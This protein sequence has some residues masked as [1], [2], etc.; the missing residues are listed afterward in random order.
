MLGAS[1]VTHLFPLVVSRLRA[2]LPGPIDVLAAIGNGRSYGRW[3]HFLARELP[4][5]LEC[6]LWPALDERPRAELRALLGD[7]GNDLVY[8]AEVAEV[9]GWIERILDRLL[10]RGARCALVRLPLENLDGLSPLRFRIARSV[11]YPGRAI[12][13][14]DLRARALDLDGCLVEIAGRR[15]VA[16]VPQRAEWYGLDPIHVLRGRREEVCRAWLAPL[17]ATPSEDGA[18]HLARADRSAFRH[19]RAERRRILGRLQVRAQPCARLL[20][21]TAISV[22]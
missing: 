14:A 10:E 13:L 12:D 9:A 16:L 18:G 8:G 7:L 4:G 11:F 21:G 20:D 15:G 17:G 2:A 19:L 1:N 3:S 22:Y 6:G 5:I